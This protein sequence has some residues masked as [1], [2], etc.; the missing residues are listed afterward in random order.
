VARFV[1][2]SAIG[3]LAIAFGQ[4]LLDLARSPVIRTGILILAVICVVGSIFSV[5]SWLRQAKERPS[6]GTRSGRYSD[7]PRTDD[8]GSKK[9]KADPMF[10]STPAPK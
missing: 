10:K 3:L 2:F 9:A 5:A 7:F 8:A 6:P 1:R 4:Q